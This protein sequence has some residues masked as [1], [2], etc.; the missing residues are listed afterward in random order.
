MVFFCGSHFL[1]SFVTV[2]V[3]FFFDRL[4]DGDC[5]SSKWSSGHAQNAEVS[6]SVSSFQIQL[7]F[8][9]LSEGYF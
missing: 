9:G 2:F 5:G 4:G 8:S 7:G 3:R 1:F 6:F